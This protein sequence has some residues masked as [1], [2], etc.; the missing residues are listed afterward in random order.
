MLEAEPDVCEELFEEVGEKAI[1]R[2]RMF[3]H[4]HLGSNPAD[5]DSLDGTAALMKWAKRRR[6]FEYSQYRAQLWEFLVE[7]VDAALWLGWLFP[8]EGGRKSE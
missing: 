1:H 7:I 3:Y 2:T 8:D 4:E 5:L 6:G